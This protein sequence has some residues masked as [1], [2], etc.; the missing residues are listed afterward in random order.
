MD[1]GLFALRM[2]IGLLFAAHGAQKLFGSFGGAGPEGT[3]G[4]FERLGL[5]PGSVHARLAGT[6]E[7]CGGLLLAFGALTA[8]GAAAVI[9]V[10]TTA[11][12][13]VHGRNGIWNTDKGYEYNLVLATAAFALAG[14]GP[15]SWSLDSAFGVADSGA[16]W[17]IGALIVGLGAG[18]G[19]VLTGRQAPEHRRAHPTA[20]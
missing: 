18:V 8:F 17:A 20:A 7:F 15:G 13:T 5:R 10:M 16:G 4:F 19:A 1:L 12:I 9:A 2:V 11:V 6:A 14:V 3:A